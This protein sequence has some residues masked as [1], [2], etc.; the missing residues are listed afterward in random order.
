[1]MADVSPIDVT[2]K[3]KEA[4]VVPKRFTNESNETVDYTRLVI[5]VTIDG[6]DS[7]LEFAPAKRE[8]RSAYAVLQLADDVE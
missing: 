2:S 4:L 7:E 1:M 6:V 5:T 3:I 8:G